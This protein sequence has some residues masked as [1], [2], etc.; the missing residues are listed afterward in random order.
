M[1]LE[2]VIARQRQ[3]P[4]HAIRWDGNWHTAQDIAWALNGR[5][6]VWCVPTG[7]EH[8]MRRAG[9]HDGSN[10]HIK[11]NARAFLIIATSGADTG[12]RYDYGCWI[13]W[14]DDDSVVRVLEQDQFDREFE[15]VDDDV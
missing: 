6:L 12:V 1:T 7:Y 14:N 2:R 15:I 3:K 5:A 9:E 13:V 11:D 4:V 10:M 8:K